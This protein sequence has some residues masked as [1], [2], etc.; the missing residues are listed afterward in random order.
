MVAM[1]ASLSWQCWGHAKHPLDTT[2]PGMP[3]TPPGTRP[4][5]PT[6]GTPTP[7]TPTPGTPTPGTP[8]PG[9]PT[10]GTRPAPAERFRDVAEQ[11]GSV[12]RGPADGPTIHSARSAPQ[13]A[14]LEASL[15]P[16]WERMTVTHH[17]LRLS[18]QP[19]PRLLQLLGHP[20]WGQK[21]KSQGTSTASTTP[22]SCA[23]PYTHLQHRAPHQE[24]QRRQARRGHREHQ[25]HR[26]H[27][28]H[29]GHQGHRG[30]HQCQERRCQLLQATSG[31]LRSCCSN[32]GKVGPCQRSA[33]I[34]M[35]WMMRAPHCLIPGEMHSGTREGLV[36]CLPRGPSEMV[37]LLL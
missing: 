37:N 17:T 23:S 5:T 22:L 16:P 21:E 36:P 7:G 27:R 30:H 9:T 18:L 13:P 1:P 3:P 31:E 32:S 24:L 2:S 15:L 33:L 14:H 29:Q 4:G 11:A 28:G 19:L 12:R 6:P 26:E 8:T 25:G 35:L 34:V 20:L 10:P